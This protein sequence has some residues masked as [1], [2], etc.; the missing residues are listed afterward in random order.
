MSINADGGTAD[1]KPVEVAQ[2][3]M[4]EMRRR[5]YGETGSAEDLSNN[6][7]VILIDPFPSIDNDIV[8][9]EKGADNLIKYGPALLGA[10]RNQLLFDS[11]DSLEAYKKEN[12]GLHVIAPS[13]PNVNN[14]QQAL[15]CGSVY[16]FGGFLSKEFRIHDYFLGR[17]NCQSFLRKYFVV[18][19]NSPDQRINKQADTVINAYK[20]NPNA[21]H[22][23]SYK[24]AKGTIWAPI[25]PDMALT[26][27][28]DPLNRIEEN[29]LPTYR[30][31]KLPNDFLEQFRADMQARLEN[32]LDNVYIGTFLQ[33]LVIELAVAIKK[34]KL[35][36]AI[37]EKIKKDL[38]KRGLMS[39]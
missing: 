33:H 5:L 34:G 31:D 30:L 8:A 18:A 17:H 36:D 35:T 25:I 3:V 32:V 13:N 26:G 39:A 29:S 15:A 2:S 24:D 14:Q 20:K 37:I 16:A 6:S 28:F 7:S 4:L 23:F 21:Q 12:Y 10:M 22:R 38:I 9:P 11:K 19:L 1:T 27:L